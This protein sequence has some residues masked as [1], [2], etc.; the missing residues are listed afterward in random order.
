MRWNKADFFEDHSLPR[1]GSFFIKNSSNAHQP[2]PTRTMTVLLRIRTRRSFCS[3]PNCRKS[4]KLETKHFP[5]AK[6]S[7]HSIFA[8]SNLEDAEFL[9]TCAQHHQATNFI[10][11]SVSFASRFLMPFW[12]KCS[13]EF[14]P[15]DNAFVMT[16][17]HVGDRYYFVTLRW[18]F[19]N[20]KSYLYV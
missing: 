3:A 19:Y 5:F 20:C 10:V 14:F 4:S 12:S 16:V 9:T 11:N 18:C 13:E 8:F 7:T 17:K 2:P 15:I 6:H 1:H